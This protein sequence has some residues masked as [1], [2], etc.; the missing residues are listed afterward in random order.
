MV[1]QPTILSSVS[2]MEKLILTSNNYIYARLAKVWES[3]K[4]FQSLTS[5][6]IAEQYRAWMD[7]FKMTSRGTT[8]PL[9]WLSK[10]DRDWSFYPQKLHMVTAYN[11][12]EKY[13]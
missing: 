5:A 12:A 4:K 11:N 3:A 13:S 1:W 2:A 10:I 7:L 8:S 6:S 9:T